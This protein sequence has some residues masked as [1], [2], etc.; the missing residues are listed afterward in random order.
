MKQE[1][2][3][4]SGK[5]VSI[6]ATNSYYGNSRMALGQRRGLALAAMRKQTNKTTRNE[7]EL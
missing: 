2:S 3:N 1:S 5:R 4:S 6:S 7:N